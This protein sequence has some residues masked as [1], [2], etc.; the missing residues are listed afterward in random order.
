MLRSITI[1]SSIFL[2]L[3]SISMHAQ[4]TQTVI[5]TD[6]LVADETQ[7][8]VPFSVTHFDTISYFQ[9]SINWDST[10]FSFNNINGL[11]LAGL[12][13]EDFAVNAASGGKIGMFWIDPNSLAT[14]LEDTVR[15][16]NITFDVISDD[17]ASSKINFGD[18]PTAREAGDVNGNEI[19]LKTIAANITFEQQSTSVNDVFSTLGM[20]VDQNTPNPFSDQTQIA[21]EIAKSEEVLFE[22]F[23]MEGKIVIR[24]KSR[25]PKGNNFIKLNKLQLNGS[26]VYQYSLT[27]KQKTITKK[28]ILL[29]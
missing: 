17:R 29:N 19:P 15:V 26:G 25:F 9:F 18:D 23:D 6:Q 22:V 12:K 20:R 4:D 16:F 3:T 7:I 13:L 5:M 1:I 2:L 8:T 27:I 28:L 21:F 11:N 10:Q 24:N 14:I